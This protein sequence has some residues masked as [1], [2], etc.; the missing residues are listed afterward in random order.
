[1]SKTLFDQPIADR[2]T[3][4]LDH[5]QLAPV[6]IGPLEAVGDHVE[7]A[8][9]EKNPKPLGGSP[10]ERRFL[11]AKRVLKFRR[12]DA[13]N[14]DLAIAEPERVAVDDTGIAA[15]RPAGCEGCRDLQSLA[16]QWSKWPDEGGIQQCAG[17]QQ[18]RDE[19]ES[20]D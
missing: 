3:V 2:R 16:S 6:P 17:K 8:L 4:A 19:P 14:A 12:V 11:R 13:G 5:H 7:G 15:P 20:P 9:I 18:D 1:M 10:G